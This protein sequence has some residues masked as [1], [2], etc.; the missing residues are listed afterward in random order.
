[1]DVIDVGDLR[2]GF[3]SRGTGSPLVLLHGALSDSRSW[4]RQLEGLSDAFTVVAWDAPGCGRSSDPPEDFQLSDYAD[5]LAEFIRKVG[6]ERPHVLGLSFGSGLALEF[7]RKYP[8]VPRT[9]LLASAYAGWAGSLPPEEVNERV[10]KARQQSEWPPE[11]VASE[12]LPTLFS[13][14]VSDEVVDETVRIL[15]EFH[16]AGMRAMLN[17]FAEADLRDVLPIIEVPTLLLYG[18]LDQRSPL[19]V[20]R[21][22]KSKIPMSTLVVIPGAGHECNVEAPEAFNSE[23]RRFLALYQD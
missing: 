4:R 1:M 22:L 19:N 9:L 5:C 20:A 12:W 23:V 11:K 6:I 7:Y 10:E 16:P 2:I 15:S 21:E 18:E 17:A 13:G 3:E 8:A 14:A